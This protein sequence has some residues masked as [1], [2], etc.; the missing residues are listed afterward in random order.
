[1]Y[2]YGEV[3]EGILRVAS[4]TVVNDQRLGRLI[5]INGKF[6]LYGDFILNVVQR[7]TLEGEKV[8]ENEIIP[9]TGIAITKVIDYVLIMNFFYDVDTGERYAYFAIVPEKVLQN[10][11]KYF[12]F[13]DI[14]SE[15]LSQE[16]DEFEIQM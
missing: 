14:I 2:F 9:T 3:V 12:R 16:L 10:I 6:L 13:W 15:N 5:L 7:I 11:I 4:D 1:M 8:E